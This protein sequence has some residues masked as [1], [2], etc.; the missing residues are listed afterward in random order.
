MIIDKA[1]AQSLYLRYFQAFKEHMPSKYLG[2]GYDTGEPNGMAASLE[3]L[4]FFANLV[5]DKN[6]V[7]LDC[8]AGLSSWLLRSWFPNVVTIEPKRME[9]YLYAIQSLLIQA[10]IPSDNFI[11]DIED[12]PDGSYAFD[13]YLYKIV[14]ADNLLYKKVELIYIDDCDTRHECMTNRAGAYALADRDNLYIRDCSEAVDQYGRW[15]VLLDT[16]KRRNGS[17][18]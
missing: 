3:S 18:K 2:F 14:A 12:A 11:V 1:E 5:P 8:G 4:L 10:K 9:G 17:R 6:R 13:D 15:G 7:I 16:T